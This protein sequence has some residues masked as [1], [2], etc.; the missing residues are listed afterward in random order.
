MLRL[1]DET[2]RVLLLAAA[3]GTEEGGTWTELGRLAEVPMAQRAAADAGLQ[4]PDPAVLAD[5][6][7]ECPARLAG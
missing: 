3:L 6:P 7:G 5:T 1:P 4:A 2:R